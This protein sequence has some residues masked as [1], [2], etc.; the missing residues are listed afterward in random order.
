MCLYDA[1]TSYLLNAYID[2]GKGS[3]SVGLSEKEKLFA[4]PTQSVVR[5]CKPIINSNKNVTAD[6]WFSSLEVVNKL[7]KRNLTYIGSLKKD[8]KT[9]PEEFLQNIRL[10]VVSSSYGFRD[11]MTLLSYVGL[12][13]K[14]QAVMLIS[15]IRHSVETNENKRKPVVT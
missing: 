4:I 2:I 8:K 11:K 15:S 12:P 10:L 6:N 7:L 3:D 13:K 9:I 14:N 5:L 1:K